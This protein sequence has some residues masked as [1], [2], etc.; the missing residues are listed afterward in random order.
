[1]VFQGTQVCQERKVTEDTLEVPG[2]GVCLECLPR[3]M[4]RRIAAQ[5]PMGI[6][7]TLEML[8][9]MDSRASL[10]TEGSQGTQDPRV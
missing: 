2:P 9:W 1:M 5:V 10:V 6:R 7:E 8:V 3:E 4:A